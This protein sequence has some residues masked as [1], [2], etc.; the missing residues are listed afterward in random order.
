MNIQIMVTNLANRTST[1]WRPNDLITIC[2]GS[3]CEKWTDLANG[4]LVRV[5][6]VVPDNGGGY[7]N[8][9]VNLILGP[10]G[11]MLSVVQMVYAYGW[12]ASIALPRTGSVTVVPADGSALGYGDGLSMGFNWG[13]G[14]TSSSFF[15][16][17]PQGGTC[18]GSHC[19]AV[20]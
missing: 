11:D 18:Y 6:P 16:P 9:S 19:I 13:G 10:P 4:Q 2:N 17:A 3:L 8:A 5:T 14:I 15:D 12:F 7:K 20:Y 1:A